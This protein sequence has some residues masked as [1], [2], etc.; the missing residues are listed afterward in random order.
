PDLSINLHGVSGVGIGECEGDTLVGLKRFEFRANPFSAIKKQVIVKSIL[1]DRPLINGIVLKD[2]TANYDIVPEGEPKESEKEGAEKNGAEESTEK[3]AEKDTDG[4]SMGIALKR[5]AIQNG[6]ISYK[7]AVMGVDA[8]M[9]DFDM[10]IKGDFSLDQTELDLMIAIDGIQ[11]KYG[12]IRYMRNGSFGLDMLAAADMINSVYT[13]KKNEI[14][15]NGLTLGAEGTVGMPEDG[16]IVTDLSFFTKETS[17]QTLLS[18]V[19]AVYLADFESLKTSGSLALN[20]TVKGIMKDS[21]LPNATVHLKVSDGYFAYPD[22][23]KDVSDIQIALNVN[24]NGTEL[25]ATTVNLERFHLL[26]G[27]NPFDI[28][29]TVDHPF[30]DMHVAGMVKG[31]IDFASLADVVPMEGLD[32]AGKMETDLH[33]DTKMSYIENEQFEEVDLDGRLVIENVEIEAPDIPVPV[34]LQKLAMH[35]TPKYV[36]LET[37]D[38]QLGASDLHLDGRLTN[39][40]PY[41]FNDQTVAGTLNVSST[42]L[43]ANEF[44][45]EEDSGTEKGVDEGAGKSAD[46]DAEMS[47]EN[48]TAP[49]PPDSMA[50]PSPVKIPQNIDFAMTL[51]LKRLVYDNIVVENLNGK[52]GVKDGVASLDKLNMGVL[53]GDITVSGTVDTRGEFPEADVE[54]DLIGIDIPTSY[55]TFVFIEKLAPIAK[56]CKGTANVEMDMYT[57]LDASF[58]PLFESIDADGHLFARNLKIEQTPTLEKLSAVLKNEKMKNLEIEKSDIRFAIR[59]GRVI[60][61]PFDVNFDNSKIIASGSHGIDQTMDYLLDMKIAKSDLGSGANDLMN[62]V[63]ALAAGA[64]FAVPQSDFL[65]VKANITGTFKDPKVKTDLSGNV[66][67]T[68]A[69]V[70]EV[71]KE[72]VTEEIKKVEVQVREDA[73]VKADKLIKDAE[74]EKAKLIEQAKV[75]GEKL[76]KEAKTQ[77]DK[78]IK[79]AGNNPIKKIAAQKTAEQMV[80]QADKQSANL[81][82][83]AEVK[84]D[85]LIEKA[86]EESGRI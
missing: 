78:L 30:S 44:L 80:K 77:G 59:E 67:E 12:G 37:V 23:P 55:E 81:I 52:M 68:K 66:S 4:T 28:S 54:L 9:E 6:R 2:G 1:L 21:L 84:G 35:F 8:A 13:L 71:V 48:L 86:K 49:T 69:A 7:D 10:E 65:K 40:I 46:E 64:G 56:S 72:K 11:A 19:P 47:T 76:K 34:R 41:V 45:A 31:M 5:F 62:S 18:M 42:L 51:D 14:R 58:N 60:V 70:K 79:E 36:N 3:G 17:F 57:K 15:I 61:E 27:G 43:D 26:L 16:S 73:S 83:Q 33:W 29:L 24:Y 82:E 50:V 85:A 32:L 22:L 74:A 53:K 25:D 38:L 20:G 63:G 75:A 39:F